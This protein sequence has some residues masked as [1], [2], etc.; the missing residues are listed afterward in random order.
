MYED[1]FEKKKRN[2]III[3]FCE[4][5]DANNKRQTRDKLVVMT[6]EATTNEKETR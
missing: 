1:E 5:Y 4:S 3:E 6:R 2:V